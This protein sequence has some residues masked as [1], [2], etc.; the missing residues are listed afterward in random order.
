ML[1][2][3]KPKLKFFTKSRFQQWVEKWTEARRARPLTRLE[4]FSALNELENLL[5]RYLP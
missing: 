3:S 5:S 2:L 4:A 1:R